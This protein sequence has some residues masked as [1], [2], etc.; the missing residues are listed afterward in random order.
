ME[1]ALT[2]GEWLKRRR[3]GLGLTQKELAELVGYAPVTLRKIEAD[4][5]RPS[6]E[7]AERLAEALRVSTSERAAFVRFAR[8]QAQANEADLEALALPLPFGTNSNVTDCALFTASSRFT[9]PLIRETRVTNA[10]PDLLVSARLVART[11]DSS[12]E[13][14]AFGARNSPVL[15]IVAPALTGKSQ[16]TRVSVVPLT[17]AVNCSVSPNASVASCGHSWTCQP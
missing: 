1:S 5:L 2:F 16:I 11:T 15:E 10:V 8:D 9:V 7:M 6:R 13:P 12:E 4:E 17:V 14:G 3:G